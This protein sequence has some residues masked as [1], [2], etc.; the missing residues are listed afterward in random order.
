MRCYRSH[1]YKRT[2][3]QASHAT[4]DDNVEDVVDAVERDVLP[5][6]VDDS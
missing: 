6:W 4:A 2:S 5:A 1:D 3:F